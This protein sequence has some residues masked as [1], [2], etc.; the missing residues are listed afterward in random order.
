MAVVTYISEIRTVFQG[1]YMTDQG[2]GPDTLL[3][4][5]NSMMRTGLGERYRQEVVVREQDKVDKATRDER[6][7]KLR[8]RGIPVSGG[9]DGGVAI[10]EGSGGGGALGVC[11]SSG[12]VVNISDQEFELEWK[13]R[14]KEGKLK[15]ESFQEMEMLLPLELLEVWAKFKAVQREAGKVSLAENI[16]G[17]FKLSER[18]AF[19][20]LE[21]EEKN[22]F[23]D[24]EVIRKGGWLYQGSAYEEREKARKAA[25]YRLEILPIS[26]PIR[27][28]DCFGS[29][30]IRE[31][32][33]EK[34]TYA[35]EFRREAEKK[36]RTIGGEDAGGMGERFGSRSLGKLMRLVDNKLVWMETWV[37]DNPK[38]WM[39][40]ERHHLAYM[41]TGMVWMVLAMGARGGELRKEVRGL[42]WDRV[43]VTA[44]LA[45]HHDIAL[46]EAESLV[47]YGLVDGEGFGWKVLRALVKELRKCKT[48]KEEQA[49]VEKVGSEFPGEEIVRLARMSLCRL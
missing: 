26:R 10:G 4:L 47:Q 13:R 23:M 7:R 8:E 35:E 14:M 24:E 15:V 11:N 5:A 38:E 45:G 40:I 44:C 27:R 18:L 29:D 36:L 9:G 31:K 16:V 30:D 6:E 22:E 32:E 3:V 2:K 41:G 37:K 17:T 21:V 46:M 19:R 43:V 25:R 48:V 42:A 12:G 1:P 20:K 49:A 34:L 39:E 28:M 33:Q